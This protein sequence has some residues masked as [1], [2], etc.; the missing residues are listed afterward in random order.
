M[1]VLGCINRE[2][3][4][5]DRGSCGKQKD[6]C[7][8]L[9]ALTCALKMPIMVETENIITNTYDYLE[10][11]DYGACY[12][13]I[14]EKADDMVKLLED[15]VTVHFTGPFGE[16]T[17]EYIEWLPDFHDKIKIVFEEC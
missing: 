16:I 11:T 1:S 6:F 5:L 4:K 10:F 15:D 14:Q 3:C 8:A 12:S 17:A 9:S 13:E 7:E 2:A